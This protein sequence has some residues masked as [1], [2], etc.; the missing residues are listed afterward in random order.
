MTIHDYFHSISFDI[1]ADVFQRCWHSEGPCMVDQWKWRSR[2]CGHGG[3]NSKDSVNA[4][5][6]WQL[7]SAGYITFCNRKLPQTPFGSIWRFPKIG[8]P[9]VII[10]LQMDFPVKTVHLRVPPFMEHPCKP[11][12][13]L[14]WMGFPHDQRSTS[15]AVPW[16]HWA[17]ANAGAVGSGEAS[18][19]L[20]LHEREGPGPFDVQVGWLMSWDNIV[21]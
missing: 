12:F 3:P 7:I 14:C 4:W 16:S 20:E 10:H 15:K 5:A 13:T 8:V 9:L 19:P 1:V 2:C 21:R 18:V 17:R 6:P 11:H